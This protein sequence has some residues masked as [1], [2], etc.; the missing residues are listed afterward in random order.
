LQ[1]PAGVAANHGQQGDSPDDRQGADRRRQEDAAMPVINVGTSPLAAAREWRG[2]SLVE[3]ARTSGLALTQ[4]EALECGDAEAFGSVDEMVA[5]AVLYS[6][7][8]GIGRDEAMALLDRTLAARR[9]GATTGTAIDGQSAQ[10]EPAAGVRAFSAAVQGR[11]S[12]SFP[13]VADDLL[14]DDLLVPFAFDNQPMP[15]PIPTIDTLRHDDEHA[16]VVPGVWHT[17]ETPIAQAAPAMPTAGGLA[18]FEGTAGQGGTELVGDAGLGTDTYQDGENGFVATED[19]L[20]QTGEIPMVRAHDPRVQAAIDADPAWRAAWEQSS[21]ELE[22]WVANRETGAGRT[23][24]RVEDAL[25]PIIGRERAERMATA[26]ARGV[27]ATR[28]QLANVR[29]QL[30]RSE[31][32]TLV[33]AVAAGVLLI[34]LLW[35]VTSLVG[36]NDDATPTPVTPKVTPS[37]QA[38]A[39]KTS[40]GAAGKVTTTTASGTKVTKAAATT[41]ALLPVKATR[42]QVLN[43]GHRTG[44]AATTGQRLKSLGYPVASVGNTHVRYPGS[45]VLY[46]PRFRR[47]AQRLAHQMG[48]ASVDALPAGAGRTPLTIVIV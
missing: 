19:E 44:A 26:G 5:A 34:G 38:A 2:V 29:G 20:G 1:E 13:I 31:R 14:E 39:A 24:R 30:E 36:G 4:A 33:V 12:R 46:Q 28:E 22:A 41:T 43:A 18:E 42:V 15:A 6:A 45:V 8:L 21:G 10:G 32:A 7:S 9:E 48:V 40:K 47:E 37:Q 17:E 27:T 11:S 16:D 25:A 3:A 35:L 23:T